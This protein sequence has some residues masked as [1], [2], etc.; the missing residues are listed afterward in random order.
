VKIAICDDTKAE[1]ELLKKYCEHLGYT[2]ISFFESGTELLA[3][4]ELSAFELLFLDIEMPD[5]SGL[6]VKNTLEQSQNPVL[7]VFSTTHAERMADAFGKNVISFLTRPF[8]EHMVEQCLLKATQ[9]L[10][11]SA[12]IQIS[13]SVAVPCKEILYVN[14]EDKYSVFYLM[15]N[16]S[17]TSRISIKQ[18]SE[19]LEEMGF[20]LISRS[21]IVN[22]KY[23][24]R[25][26]GL[27]IFL[28][29]GTKLSISRRQLKTVNEKLQNYR[30]WRSAG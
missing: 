26:Q 17:Y 1:R 4:D 2:D 15:K 29:D 12:P 19:A 23:V 5:M 6:E 20:C 24:L 25:I 22:L 11:D 10:K 18:W 28:E 14:S 9:L 7:I 3:S 13:E 8:D 27:H 21:A 30:L 16:R